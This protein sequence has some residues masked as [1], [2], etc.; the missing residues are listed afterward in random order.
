MTDPRA[1]LLELLAEALSD[2]TFVKLTLSK[3]RQGALPD[4]PRQVFARPVDLRAGPHLSLLF[5]HPTRDVTRNVPLAAARDEI[6]ALLA[7]TF[8]NAHLFTTGADLE[9]ATNKRGEARL[10][11]HAATF[12]EAP[13]ARHDR[14]KRY[15]LDPKTSPWLRELGIV[16][17]EGHVKS[18]KADKYRQLQSIVKHVDELVD[19]AGLRTRPRLRVVDF[20]CG[21]AYLTFALYDYFN[22]HLGVPTEVVGVDRNAALMETCAGVAARVGYDRLTFTCS[23]VEEYDPGTAD[24]IVAL[25]ACDTA[26]DL[27][28]YRGVTSGAALIVTVPCC[29]KELRPQLRPPA[30]ELPLLRHDTF[31]D[32]YAQMLTDGLRALLMD[33]EGYRT[34]VFE[35]ISDAHTH[36]NVMIAAVRP[37]RGENRRAERRAE[38]EALKAR[39]GLTEQRLDRLLRDGAPL[40]T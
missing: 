24:V 28:L 14:A 33:G 6:A 17:P 25:H 36:R 31:K 11:R 10:Q 13:D 22:T 34:R 38:A 16:S 29:Q 23:S 21:K 3:P 2:G 27:A 8:A 15:V 1:R 35:F 4:G 5:R 30:D 18:D 40:R 26:T 37:E 9:L 39:Y 19:G 7:D 32:R 20:G 12:T